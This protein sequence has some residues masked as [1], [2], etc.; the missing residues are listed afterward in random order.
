MMKVDNLAE[1]RMKR[2]QS[3]HLPYVERARARAKVWLPGPGNGPMLAVRIQRVGRVKRFLERR[4]ER[5]GLW[6]G[7]T[8][9]LTQSTTSHDKL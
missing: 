2:Q 3:L 1:V 9:N 6:S 7:R 5:L 4:C 8:S